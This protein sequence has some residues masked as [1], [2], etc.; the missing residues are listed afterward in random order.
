LFDA[1]LEGNAGRTMVLAAT[2]LQKLANLVEFEAREA[3]LD[4]LNPWLKT[5]TPTFKVPFLV[6]LFEDIAAIA[7]GGSFITQSESFCLP[8]RLGALTFSLMPFSH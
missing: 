1:F 3:F 5:Q 4:R 8:P 2:A 7:L 6:F